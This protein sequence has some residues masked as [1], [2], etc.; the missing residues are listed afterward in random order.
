MTLLDTAD[1]YGPFTNEELVGRA[2]AGPP[3]R[4]RPGHQVRARGRGRRRVRPAPATAARSTCARRSRARCGG[5]APTSSTSTSCTASIPRC[6]WRRPG[7]RWPS[8]SRQGKVGAIGMSE[9]SV[10]RARA[11]ARDPPGR[12]RAV[13]GLA[14]DARRVRGGRARGARR[15]APRSCP[16]APLGRGFLTGA[17]APQT[18]PP[19][20]FRKNNPRFQP[21]AMDANARPRRGRQGGRRAPRR[22]AGPGRAGLAAG[23][24][25]ARRPDPGHQAP[26]PA[27]GERRRGA[28]T[29]VADGPRRARRA[30]G[31]G[32]RPL[33]ST[34]RRL[35][36][37]VLE[38]STLASVERLRTRG[39]PRPAS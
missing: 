14:V 24:G 17:L 33:L 1:M 27:R 22:D 26:H 9:V 31:P 5:W 39:R 12:L 11:R 37:A 30:P 25:R 18:F 13:R 4:G 19:G 16:F 34:E 10:G 23:A 8:S 2:I 3:R 21:E 7:A 38:K 35:S 28:L 20:D 29:L 15:T 32:R 6:R 36:R